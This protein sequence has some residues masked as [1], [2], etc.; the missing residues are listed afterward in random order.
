VRNQHQRAGEIFYAVFQY[1][2]GLDVQV[3][4]GLV[5]EQEV[6]RLEHQLRYEHAGLLA[7]G[8]PAHG[9]VQLLRAEQEAVR[10][11]VHVDEIS[12]VQN[13]LA[14]RAKG[15]AQRDA[16]VQLVAVLV[17]DRDL[18]VLRQFDGS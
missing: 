6:G 4:G 2:E 8:K 15:F 10:P 12:L 7:A 14:G 5:Q 16:Q 9:E 17:E 11:F 3:V 13:V 18:E 1:L